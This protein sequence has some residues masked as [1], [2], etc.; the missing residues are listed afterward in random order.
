MSKATH[1]ILIQGSAE[2]CFDAISTDSR[3]IRLYDFFVPLRGAQFDGHDFLLP[4]LEAGARGS[5]VAADVNRETLPRSSD[6]VLIQVQD[7]LRALSDLASAHRRR[8]HAPLIA[9][10][11]SSGKTTTKEMIA[12]ILRVGH[13][14]LVSAGN[15]NNLIGLPMSVLN[16]STDHSAAVVEAGINT[17][18]EME[19]LAG[20]AQPDVAVITSIGP[21]HLEGLGSIRGVAE[22]KFKLVESVP[23]SGTAV[24]PHGQEELSHLL[25][26][27][28]ARVTTFGIDEGDFRAQRVS[29]RETIGFVMVSPVGEAFIEMKIPGKH[30]VSN[31][32]AA[33]AACVA[34]GTAMDEVVEGLNRFEPPSWRMETQRLPDGRT[35]IRDFYNANPQSVEAALHALADYDPGSSKMA[36]LADMMEL[37]EFAQELHREIGKMCAEIGIDHCVFI[38]S[39]C[40]SFADGFLGAGGSAHALTTATDRDQAW[41]A[42]RDRILSFRTILIKGS[43]RMR[44]ELFADRIVQEN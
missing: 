5:L 13:R 43:R 22:E 37:G 9:V 25:G 7:T 24:L 31:A 6:F 15:L 34:V 14:P 16:L 36:I 44:M 23:A 4:A 30:N 12:A 2:A 39:H 20:A 11:G 42:L 29:A 3:D 38:G 18:G 10:T 1:G 41:D 40:G 32:L 26:R 17:T 27:C 28:R 33:A 19:L 8:Y 35:V 21:V